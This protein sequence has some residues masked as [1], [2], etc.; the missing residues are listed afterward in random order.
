MAQPP[1]RR[2]ILVLKKLKLLLVKETT[3]LLVTQ[4][5]WSG[6]KIDNGEIVW[7]NWHFRFRLDPRVGPV[8]NL[9]VIRT[10]ISYVR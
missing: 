4:P 2:A 10:T 1:W 6:Y 3:P 7:Q 5:L 8:V 9:Y